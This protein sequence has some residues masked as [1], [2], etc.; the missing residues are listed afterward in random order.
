M[1]R[2]QEGERAAFAPVYAALRPLV[3]GY[4]AKIVGETDAEDV[5]QASLMKLFEQS[6]RYDPERD[7]VA[8]AL[9]LTTWEARTHRRKVTRRREDAEAPPEPATDDAD[10]RIVEAILVRE[11]QAVLETLSDRD[12]ETLRMAFAERGSGATFRKQKERALSRLRR[13][14]KVIHG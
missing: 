5:A 14:W 2:L 13:A 9:T 4:A 11:A 12:R 3:L 6:V 8:W 1:A 10:D 7:A